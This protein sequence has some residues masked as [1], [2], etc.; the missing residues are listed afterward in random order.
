MVNV[1]L[2][3]GTGYAGEDV[4][5]KT[6]WAKYLNHNLYVASRIK[7][8]VHFNEALENLI[9]PDELKN[10]KNFI[11]ELM[12][13]SKEF[14]VIYD[15]EYL[16]KSY[17]DAE[18]KDLE[19]WLGV[20]F[21][22]ISSLDRR[23]YD[24]T[25]LDDIRDQR[26]LNNYL[27]GLLVFFKQFFKKN[28][29]NVFINTLEDDVFSLMAYF[30][31][32]RLGLEVI[33]FLPGRFPKKGIIL[34]E[35]FSE[36]C[37][38]RKLANCD[39]NSIHSMYE[40]STLVGRETLEFNKDFLSFGSLSLKYKKF[41]YALTYGK[42]RNHILNHY[43]YEKFILEPSNILNVNLLNLLFKNT[44][45]M[46]RSVFLR[47]ILKTPDDGSYFL[48]PLHYV[49][50]AQITFRE[51]LLDQFEL[52]RDISRTL[53][54]DSYLYVKPHPHYMGSDVSFKE[55][56][57]ISKLE[58]VKVINPTYPPIELIINSKGV[59][60]VNSTTGFEALV[61]GVPVI[62]LGHDFYCKDD[63]CYVIRENK[64]LS[65][66]IMDLL[67]DDYK[68][69]EKTVENFLKKVYSNTIWIDG[70][71]YGDYGIFIPFGL[72]ESDGKHIASA[73]DLI[74]NDLNIYENLENIPN[75]LLN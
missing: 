34:C 60:T 37:D 26:G 12:E 47:F 23:F 39:L 46:L 54:L 70:V 25:K 27:A 59:I 43:D 72:T 22:Y 18:I 57:K 73:L 33:G 6:P 28:K 11:D 66:K 14:S 42:F 52:I 16:K 20:P 69:D 31:A 8:D 10:L 45:K 56:S 41:K 13:I 3:V 49:E 48:F 24:R 58:N 63:L 53:P 40:L 36:I 1:A 32:K 75:D 74:L 17:T 65:N 68:I 44:K 38:F 55:L 4:L 50:D 51:P 29:I 61:M 9:G 67:N 21:R 30:V 5:H 15:S 64:D 62:T 35:D 19:K 2:V 7:T 71:D